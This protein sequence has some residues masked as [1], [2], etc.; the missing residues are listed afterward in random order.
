MSIAARLTQQALL[1]TLLITP[2]SVVWSAVG[3]WF[4]SSR[5]VLPVMTLRE[6][7]P[8]EEGSL[9]NDNRGE[10]RYVKVSSCLLYTSPSPRD[11][12]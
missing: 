2:V 1:L 7:E 9:P 8:V 4:E 10:L 11:R 5:P 6:L 3:D 12:G